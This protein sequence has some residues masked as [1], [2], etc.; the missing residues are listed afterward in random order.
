MHLKVDDFLKNYQIKKVFELAS[1]DF[2]VKEFNAKISFM[3]RFQQTFYRKKVLI[4]HKTF[5]IQ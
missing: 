1:E 2:F 4:S 3:D 5:N